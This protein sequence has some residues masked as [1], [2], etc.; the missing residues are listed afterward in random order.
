MVDLMTLRVGGF[1][2]LD[3][4]SLVWCTWDDLMRECPYANMPSSTF[5]CFP[6]SYCVMSYLFLDPLYYYCTCDYAGYVGVGKSTK[7]AF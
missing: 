7:A 2:L 1:D 3:S 6:S 4:S 5:E